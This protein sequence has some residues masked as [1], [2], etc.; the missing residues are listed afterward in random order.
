MIIR[1]ETYSTDR[2]IL[3]G[4]IDA[5]DHFECGLRF[6]RWFD[7]A[8]NLW[9]DDDLHWVSEVIVCDRLRAYL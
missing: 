4:R 1:R 5:F 8:G 6:C 3:K 7:K 2:V 9:L